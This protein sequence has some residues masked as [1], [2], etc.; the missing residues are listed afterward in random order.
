GPPGHESLDRQGGRKSIFPGISYPVPVDSISV[1]DGGEAPAPPVPVDRD[2]IQLVFLGDGKAAK[3]VASFRRLLDI[4]DERCRDLTGSMLPAD[5]Q[6]AQLE[7]LVRD[8]D[9]EAVS[10]V[11]VVFAGS[12]S[13]DPDA[14]VRLHVRAT[15][16]EHPVTASVIGL[17]SLLEC[18]QDDQHRIR[19]Y[20][21]LDAVDIRGQPVGP[22]GPKPVPVL[23]LG[24]GDGSGRG[25]AE[26]W[27]GLPMPPPELVTKLPH[28]GPLSLQDLH[29]LV[30]GELLEDGHSPARQVGPVRRPRAPPPQGPATAARTARTAGIRD[31]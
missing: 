25:L 24:R 12:G 4:P 15:D 26:I 1:Q 16:P 3:A 21:I 23:T 28:W 14:G 8:L 5:E 19:G 17:A 18:L 27:K 6:L 7:Q 31:H 29:G 9:P 10:D 11:L 22:T 13:K 20:V 2:R 30:G